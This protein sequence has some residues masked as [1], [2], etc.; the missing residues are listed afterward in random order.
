MERQHLEKFRLKCEQALSLFK[1][2][3]RDNFVRYGDTQ[4]DDH[5]SR[6]LSLTSHIDRKIRTIDTH[7]DSKVV[8]NL[9]DEYET[10]ED[11]HSTLI[12]SLK[13]EFENIDKETWYDTHFH[14]WKTMPER[15]ECE[16]YPITERLHYS[17]CR[18]KMFEHTENE[19]KK[20]VFP[21]LH[22]RLEFFAK[23]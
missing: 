11:I 22:N 23:S 12:N 13:Q 16:H 10:F 19:W 15:Q 9:Y 5:I 7:E 14:N 21:T 6:L 20:S 18:L 2:K 1:K 17:K 4:Y 8:E 3:R